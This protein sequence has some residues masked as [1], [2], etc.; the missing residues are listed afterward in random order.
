MFNNQE[1]SDVTVKIHG[2]KLY[3]HRFVICVQSRYFAK[4]FQAK[5]FKE[6][7]M[8]VI[9]FD[10]D[11]AMAHWRVFEYL[12]TGHYSDDLSV[13]GL[14]DIVLSATCAFGCSH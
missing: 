14:Q 1:Y 10:E 7:E 6:G 5:T 3:A 4:A 8:G 11:S 2:T 12:H 9:E 13:E